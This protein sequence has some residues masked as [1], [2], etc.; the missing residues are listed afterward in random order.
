MKRN[1]FLINYNKRNILITGST[2]KIGSNLS[3]AYSDLGANLILT[4]LDES[5]LRYLKDKIL[6]KN[7]GLKISIFKCDLSNDF[8]RKN[9]INFVKKKFKKIDIIVNNAG[10]LSSAFN[11]RHWIGSSKN[12]SIDYWRK[13]LEVNVT[14]VFDICKN[15]KERFNTKEDANIIN[16]GS[17]YGHVAPRF[18][19]YKNLKMGN[20]AGYAV[21]KSGLSQ[22]T[23][24]FAA[25]FSPGIRV[26]ELAIGG[27]KRG[28]NKIF[29]SRYIKKT[30][31]KRMAK[32]EDI[33]NA[34]V[35]FTSS[36]SSYITGQ[37]IFVDGGFS[38]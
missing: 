31:L 38:I 6:K 17:I 22:L 34:V 9:L 28:Q 14:A 4:D 25:E 13:S 30:L 26:N 11:S 10:V 32:E 33:V 29:I 3:I 18:S 20:P 12:Q 35:F 15:L 27:I 24:W 7:K 2:G 36:L 23:K 19:L 21:S 37:T 16:L 5:K 8:E 1:N